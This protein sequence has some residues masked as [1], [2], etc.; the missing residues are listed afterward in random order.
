[1]SHSL[2]EIEALSKCAARGAGLSWGMAEETGKAIRWLES[3]GLPGV[4]M[5]ASLLAQN[6][7][8]AHGAVAP[9]FLEGTRGLD[10]IWAASSGRLCPLIAGAALNDCADR[11]TAGHDIEMSNVSHP[12]LAV[13]FAAWAAIHLGAPVTVAWG[14]F[15]GETD[16]YGLWVDDPIAQIEAATPAAM[17]FA[18]A[19][20]AAAAA[21][22]APRNDPVLAPGQ[23]GH[24]CLAAWGHL[25]TFAHRTY[26]PAS[27][28]SRLLG[29]GAG[30]SDND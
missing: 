21:P 12:L 28:T 16:G 11:L 26:A 19:A 25:N 5:L 29:A 30:E 24:V 4:A 2:N 8:I 14:R 15:R 23:R 1:M 6:D 27:E 9:Q 10:G 22:A 13:P 3:H 17:S 18:L 20:P 7:R